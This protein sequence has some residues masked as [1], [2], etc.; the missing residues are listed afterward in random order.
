MIFRWCAFLLGALVCFGLTSCSGGGGQVSLQGTGATF[1]APL[2][3]QWFQEFG[4]KNKDIRVNYQAKGSGAG[5]QDF[6]KGLVD[7]G[8]SDAAMKDE[9][10]KEVERGVQFLPATAGS[11]V[12]GYNL[13]DLKG[14]LKLSRD[15]YIGIFL[16]KIT[17][18]NDDK[19]KADNPGVE[20]PDL[21]ISVI[22]RA[23]G[24]GTTYVFTQ[25]LAAISPE[26]KAGPGVGTTVEWPKDTIGGKGNDGVT[27]LIKQTPGAIGYIEFG[28]AEQTKL[29]TALLQNKSGNF[30][31][32]SLESGQAALAGIELPS[33]LRAW[34]PDPEGKEAYP[35]VTFTWI[36]LYKKYDDPKK[37]EA[38]KE[39]FKYCLTDG[40]KDAAGLGY[41]PLPKNVVDA[42]LKA[43]DGLGK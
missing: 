41:I 30:I 37:L 29:P 4:K 33:N 12:V 3:Q 43:L 28:Y 6:K 35:I 17:K 10:V 14:E 38:I 18:W 42:G 23:D 9:E 11:I 1:P 15:A 39:V 26:W 5:I 16:T 8:A 40:Q 24:A 25:H 2:Y 20:L 21:K 32:A 22:R 19:I 7:F 27:A 13:P 36:L 31:K 34:A